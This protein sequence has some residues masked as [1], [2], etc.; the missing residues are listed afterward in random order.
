MRDA[1]GVPALN[2]SPP[3]LMKKETG[4][5]CPRKGG[6]SWRGSGMLWEHEY[7]YF[8]ATEAEK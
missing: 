5:E 1:I 4:I 6:S 3:W 2:D 8:R 7:R